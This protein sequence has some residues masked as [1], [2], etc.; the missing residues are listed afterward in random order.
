MEY[1]DVLG[2]QGKED[3]EYNGM[4]ARVE[5]LAAQGIVENREA[6]QCVQRDVRP[7]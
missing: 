5:S 7:R 4:L 6:W 2:L 1:S 3:L